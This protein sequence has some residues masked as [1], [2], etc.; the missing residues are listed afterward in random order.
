[1]KFTKYIIK[2]KGLSPPYL[3]H[4]CLKLKGKHWGST[5]PVAVGGVGAPL[6]PPLA[7]CLLETYACS[8]H[9]YVVIQKNHACICN[10]QIYFYNT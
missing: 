2:N 10:I 3:I 4:L 9:V 5:G 8:M 7:P 1:M 6:A